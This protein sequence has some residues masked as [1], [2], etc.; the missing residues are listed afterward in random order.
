M[1]SHQFFSLE[2]NLYAPDCAQRYI[3]I[4]IDSRSIFLPKFGQLE[5]AAAALQ[6]SSANSRSSA[7]ASAN[8]SANQSVQQ[9]E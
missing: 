4:I 8:V 3:V 5:N 1:N 6:S 2:H 9:C 7:A